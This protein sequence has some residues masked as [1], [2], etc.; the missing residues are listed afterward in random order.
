MSNKISISKSQL[1]FLY[2]EKRLSARKI[3][4]IFKC[5]KTAIL[6]KLKRYGIIAR[7]PKSKI[8]IQK[9]DLKNFYLKQKLSTYGV[10]KI[11][12]CSPTAIYN[13]LKLYSI[14]TRPLKRVEITKSALEELYIYKKYPFSKI[15]KI[16]K[17]NTVCI[18]NKMRKFGIISRSISEANTRYPKN[19]FS[20]DL[21]EKA[22]MIGFRLGDLRVRKSVNLIKAGCGTTKE[23]QINLIKSLF[24]KYGHVWVS[25][26]NK[27]GVVQVDASLNS[28]FDFLLPKHKSIPRWILEDELVFL[29]FL[30]GY[31]DAEGNIQISQNRAKF[32]IRT[33]DKKILHDLNNGLNKLGVRGLFGLE[34]NAGISKKGVRRNK[35][36]WAFSINERKSL[37][38]I[39]EY[40][41]PLLRHKKRKKDLEKGLKNV[42]LRLKNNP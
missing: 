41:Q 27:I 23:D 34:S 24:K 18:L 26:R 39:F 14:Q 33:Y 40:L 21:R 38:K 19:N 28:S 17:C 6:N 30:A 22:Y 10:A 12:N 7:H 32:R 5:D 20:G 25:A 31:T 3:A 42:V 11:F 16:Y 13:Y 1:N 37:L 8:V 9:N 15:A 29:N 4:I 2:F 35:D 36:C